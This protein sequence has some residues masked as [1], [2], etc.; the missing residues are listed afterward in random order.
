[1][2]TSGHTLAVMGGSGLYEMDGLEGVRELSVETPYGPPSDVIVE[3]TLRSGVGEQVR[4]LFLP[5]HGKGHR[6]SPSNINYRANVCALKKAGATH[7]VSISAV[8][9]MLEEIVPGDLVVVDQFIDL[10]KRR[11]STFFDEG[12]VAHVGFGDPV[13]KLLSSAL[14]EAADRAVGATPSP[15]PRAPRVHRGGTYVCMEGPQFSTRAES[16]VY[17]SWGVSVIGMTGMPEAKLAREAELPF[18]TLALATDYDC[19]HESEADVSVEAVLAVVSRNVK[20]AQRAVRE[21]AMRLPDPTES[22]AHGAL[23]HA[24]MTAKDKIPEAAR[25]KLSWLVTF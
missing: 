6:L 5:R 20:L 22:R 12:V 8:G 3:G 7:L 9:S 19:W 1:M 11:A 2:A 18:A 15:T 21:L 25:A 17:R 13:C 10:T 23:A 24:V 4:L 14:H 16:M